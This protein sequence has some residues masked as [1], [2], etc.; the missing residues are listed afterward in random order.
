MIIYDFCRLCGKKDITILQKDF[1]NILCEC[2]KELIP[3]TLDG[4]SLH[5][6]QSVFDIPPCPKCNIEP[7]LD[8]INIKYESF[9]S[10]PECGLSTNKEKKINKHRDGLLDSSQEWREIIKK[11]IVELKKSNEV[12]KHLQTIKQLFL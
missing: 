1:V 3:L 4:L 9:F 5:Y 7:I 6:Y 8:R 12:I 2:R 11:T 10:C